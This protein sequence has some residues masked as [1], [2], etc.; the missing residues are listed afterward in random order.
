MTRRTSFLAAMG[1]TAALSAGD[2]RASYMYSVDASPNVQLFGRSSRLVLSG[3]GFSPVL[4]GP[5]FAILSGVL[6]GSGTTPPATDTTSASVTLDVHVFNV[7]VGRGGDIF[8]TGQ[9]TVTSTNTAG[10][11]STFALSSISPASLTLGS[12][13]YTLSQL[14]YDPPSGPTSPFPASGRF[15]ALLGESPVPEPASIATTGVGLAVLL[16]L[17]LARLRGG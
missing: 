8:V 5:Q 17:R 10:T 14:V 7:D 12:F 16:G 15:T 2:V 13:N 3:S 1:L 9:L 11:S 4:T 6:I